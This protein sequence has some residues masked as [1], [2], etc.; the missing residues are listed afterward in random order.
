M[1]LHSATAHNVED[2]KFR[3]F[4]IFVSKDIYAMR[5]RAGLFSHVKSGKF[6]SGGN[7]LTSHDHPKMAWA[8]AYLA[9][10]PYQSLHDKSSVRPTF[11]YMAITTYLN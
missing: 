7:K 2:A 10:G 8:V 3:F 6:S 4:A 11:L 5:K 9:Q 1:T